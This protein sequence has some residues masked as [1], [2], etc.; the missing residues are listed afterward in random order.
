MNWILGGI[1]LVLFLIWW[2]GT[3]LLSNLNES[4]LLL[5]YTTREK[6]EHV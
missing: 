6:S 2:D 4:V 1:L 3:K 5:V